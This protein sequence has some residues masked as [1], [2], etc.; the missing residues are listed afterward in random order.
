[1]PS[2]KMPI[3]LYLFS[4]IL[5]AIGQYLYQLGAKKLSVIPLYKNFYLFGGMASFMLVMVLF[6]VAFRLGG[7]L[8]V[9]YP[10][11][12]TTFIWGALIASLLGKE[13]IS[14]LQWIGIAVIILGVSFVAVGSGR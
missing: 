13:T 4:G 14:S 10:F 1:M 9:V 6:V 12:A 11:Y 2:Q 5:G 3:F 7:K 8:S